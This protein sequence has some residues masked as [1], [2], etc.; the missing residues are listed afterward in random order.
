MLTANDT[1]EFLWSFHD[2]WLLITEYKGS[3]I[4]SDPEYGGDNTIKP[5]SGSIWNFC[6][7]ERIPYTRG[8]GT[9]VIGSYC[10]PDVKII[11]A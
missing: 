5:F 3:F 6:K 2:K 9:H 10:G 7:T 11:G 4:W 1:A 8:K